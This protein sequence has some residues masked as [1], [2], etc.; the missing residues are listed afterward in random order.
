MQYD[1]IHVLPK[2]DSDPMDSGN[3]TTALYDRDYRSIFLPS[4]KLL[5]RLYLIS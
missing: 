1:L 2:I 3:A 4:L 5:R